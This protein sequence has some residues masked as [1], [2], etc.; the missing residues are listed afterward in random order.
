[1]NRQFKNMDSNVYYFFPDKNKNRNKRDDITRRDNNTISKIVSLHF[2]TLNEIMI[3]NKIKNIENYKKQY[4]VFNNAKKL[5]IAQREDESTNHLISEKNNETILLQFD[6]IPIIYLNTYLKALSSSKKYIFQLL[7]FYKCLLQS[8]SSL[9][10][11]KII[12][13]KINFDSIIIDNNEMPLFT[14]F[15]YSCDITKP[16]SITHFLIEYRPTYISWTLE[17]HILAYILTNK[18]DSLSAFNIE[19]IIDEVTDANYILK[20][21]GETIVTSYKTDAYEYFKKYVNQSRDFI[22]S[23]IL[24]FYKTW[25]NYALSIM[26]LRVFIG[27]HKSIQH[28]RKNDNEKN[29]N[30]KNKFIIMF[31][32][33]LVSNISLNPQSRHSIGVTINN[34]ENMLYILQPKD[35]KLIIDNLD[36]MSS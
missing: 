15:S 5:N 18:L 13:N 34:F 3:V 1:M 17:F 32:K 22:I 35:Y 20:T 33:L 19:K 25:D 9:I 31:M 24:Q 36:L 21:F 7:E 23:D 2:F 28:N 29:D 10:D 6:D 27:I 26:Y 8:I 11:N 14:N 12:H 4:Y 16:D 30:E